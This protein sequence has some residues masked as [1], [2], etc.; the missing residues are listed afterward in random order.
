MNNI[1]Q[2]ILYVHICAG[3][4]A[5][6]SGA[7]AISTSKG[8][9]KHQKAGKIYAVAMLVVFITGITIASYK[10]NKFLF[11]IAFISYYSVFAGVRILKLKKLHKG[12]EARWFDWLAGS[13][14]FIANFS[15][16]CM[17]V[18]YAVT[19][20]VNVPGVLLSAGF[21]LGGMYLSYINMKPFI[22][23]PE[24]AYHWY[25]YHLGN[26]MGG[27]I[28]TFTAF[29]STM[30][31]RFEFMNPFLAFALPSL[32]GIPFIIYWTNKTELKFN[33]K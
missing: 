11:L 8:K 9:A 33:T 25:T 18:Y 13:I 31:T 21:G 6:L 1:I 26:M 30:V 4:I 20:D 2:N 19:P 15:F 10:F 32:I 16:V 5:L 29:F 22:S 12:Q 28:A 23:K 17:A 7:V 14:N 24:K 3:A 27:Y